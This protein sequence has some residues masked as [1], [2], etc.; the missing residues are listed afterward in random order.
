MNYEESSLIEF[1]ET[2]LEEIRMNQPQTVDQK[3][4]HCGLPNRY[5]LVAREQDREDFLELMEAT[6]EVMEKYNIAGNLLADIKAQIAITKAKG[7]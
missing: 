7:E 4:F 6:Y 1:F 2:S 5:P 3:C